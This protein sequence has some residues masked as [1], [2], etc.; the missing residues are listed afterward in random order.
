ME[1]ANATL[2]LRL[3]LERIPALSTRDSN[4]QVVSNPTDI[5]G[6]GVVQY[7]CDCGASIKV[8]QAKDMVAHALSRRHAASAAASEAFEGVSL[9]LSSCFMCVATGPCLSFS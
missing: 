9:S 8:L 1:S 4:F 7:D 5:A 6:D 3:A 2:R